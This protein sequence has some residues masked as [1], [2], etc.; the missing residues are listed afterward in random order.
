MK[1]KIIEAAIAE[2]TK[3]GL[4]FTMSDVAQSL[5]ISKKTIYTV[6]ESKQALMMGI[7]DKYAADFRI[8]QHEIETDPSLDTVEKIT[9]ILIGL[10]SR[11]Q[12]IGLRE[13]Y[14]FAEKYPKVYKRLMA[15]VNDGWKLAESYIEQ[16][17]QE[18]KIRP[19][20]V[21]IV[22]AMVEGTV[23]KFLDSRILVDNGLSYEEG[24]EQMINVIINGIR[25]QGYYGKCK[26]T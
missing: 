14:D 8:M 6:F 3:N 21:P 24:K 7:A 1:T 9:K 16:G 5:S 17:I 13:M 18:Q 22:M 10:P 23:H 2:F 12:N 15:S 19:V 26:N 4:K 25:K 20:S 11:Y